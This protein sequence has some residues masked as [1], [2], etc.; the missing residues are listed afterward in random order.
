MEGGDQ[1]LPFVRMFYGTPS[2]YLWEDELGVTQHIAQGEGGEQGDPL[3]PMLFALVQHVALEAAQG[4]LQQNERIFAYLDDVYVVSTPDRV[5]EV[6]QVLED[7]L[8]S[9]CNIHVHQGKTQVWNRAGIAPEGIDVLTSRAIDNPSFLP[10]DLQGLKVLGVPIGQPEYVKAFLV[11]KSEAQRELFQRIPWVEDTQAAWLLLLMCGST[12]AN[13]WLRAV[14]PELS[15]GF[16]SRHDAEVWRCLREILGTPRAPPVA[17]VLSSLSLSLGGCGLTS[18]SRVRPA[19]HWSSWAD[20]LRMVKQRHPNLAATMI[21]ELEQGQH[22]SF[23]ARECRG[24]S[25]EAGLDVPS[26]GDLSETLPC[27]QVWVAAEGHET[28]GSAVLP[29]LRVA[30]HGGP[31]ASSDEV[32]AWPLGF[33]AP[34][35]FTNFSNDEIGRPT[36]P[37]LLVQ[38]TPFASSSDPANLP[39]CPPARLS[40]PKSCSVR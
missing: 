34:D 18:A 17:Q 2:T 28:T 38:A 22:P 23:T 33:S 31:G 39:M 7:T 4:R 24:A 15:G 6:H 19:A 11:R 27:T 25:V 32:S 3:M 8:A 37:P 35:R 1:I 30:F 12:R 9:H 14:R 10:V 16:A 40:W 21:H 13:F 5:F 26:W 20:C 29:G 36:I